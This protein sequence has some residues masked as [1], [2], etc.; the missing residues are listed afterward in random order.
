MSRQSRG[1]PA[2]RTAAALALG[3]AALIA[4]CSSSGSPSS[5]SST[6][7]TPATSAPATASPSVTMTA[8]AAACKHINSLRASLNDLTHLTLNASAAKQIKADLG[9]V[10]T[11]LAALKGEPGASAFAAEASQLNAALGQVKSAAQHATSDPSHV[12]S[13]LSNLKS[14]TTTMVAQMKAA[15]PQ[16]S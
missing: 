14:K 4:G 15:C 5:S 6:T 9:N 13:A 10:S 3:G 2:G 8:S 16:G 11:Q 12:V 1:R 7:T